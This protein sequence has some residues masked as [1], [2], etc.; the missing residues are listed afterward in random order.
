MRHLS[1]TEDTGNTTTANNITAATSEVASYVQ[2]K[3]SNEVGVTCV[4]P[5]LAQLFQTIRK[6]HRHSVSYEN[7]NEAT[8]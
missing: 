1:V 4:D 7:R 6:G 3:C 2:P 8:Y 5:F